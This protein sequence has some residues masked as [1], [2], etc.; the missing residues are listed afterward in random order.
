MYN[1]NPE[2]IG[3]IRPDWDSLREDVK[4]VMIN[5]VTFLAEMPDSH[6]IRLVTGTTEGIHPVREPFKPS[7]SGTQSFKPY[8][9]NLRDEMKKVHQ[10]RC[11]EYMT[12]VLPIDHPDV[13]GLLKQPP[14]FPK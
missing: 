7:Y 9:S 10:G 13:S 4:K 8:Y 14:D 2:D 12:M 11:S 6:P 5:N 1:W 3:D